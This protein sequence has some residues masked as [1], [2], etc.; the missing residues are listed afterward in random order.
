M[1]IPVLQSRAAAAIDRRLMQTGTQLVDL[2]RVESP[3]FQDDL[4]RV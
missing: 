1:V 2:A 4:R 3:T